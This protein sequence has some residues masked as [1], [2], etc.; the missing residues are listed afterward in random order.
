[1]RLLQSLL[2]LEMPSSVISPICW[3]NCA[4]EGWS[5]SINPRP[6]V[7]QFLLESDTQSLVCK[8]FVEGAVGIYAWVREREEIG[9]DKGRCQLWCSCN[10][11]GSLC[12]LYLC[13]SIGLWVAAGQDLPWARELSEAE[14]V[15]GRWGQCANKIPS[16]KGNKFLSMGVRVS[17]SATPHPSQKDTG[18][19]RPIQQSLFFVIMSWVFPAWWWLRITG[20]FCFVTLVYVAY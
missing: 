8:R 11:N 16:N 5:C 7:S 20:S 3:L 4:F 10:M 6:Y 12:S 13:V 9:L 2:E 1:M 15:F 18:T 14:A 17:E 19:S